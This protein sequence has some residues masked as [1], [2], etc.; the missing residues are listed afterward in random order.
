MTEARGVLTAT[1][2]P[3]RAT[4]A[5]MT[6]GH[7][8]LRVLLDLGRQPLAERDDGHVYPLGLVECQRCGLVQN[9]WQVDRDQ[10]FPADHPYATGDTAALRAHFGGLAAEAALLLGDGDLIV[11][12][13]ANDGT[14]LAQVKRVA[15]RAR[16]LAV[17]PTGQAA[18]CRRQVI[19][20][21]QEFFTFAA[22]RRITAALGQARVITASNVLAHVADQHDFM[23]GVAHLLAPGGTFITENHDLT[24]VINGL[25]I[26]T[27]YHEHLRFYSV[28]SLGYLLSIHGFGAARIEEIPTH[29]GSFR[30]FATRLELDLQGRAGRA[31]EELR[32]LLDFAA[33]DG[34]I[35][36]VGAATR[37][38]PL[39]HFAGLEA[40]LDAI[41]EVPGN[42][43]IGRDFPGTSIPVVD[44]A[45]LTAA[46]PPWAV[47][48]A[49]HIAPTLVP[50]LRAA[51]YTGQFIVPLPRPHIYRG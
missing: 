29:G 13:G 17:E 10:V 21:E 27:V 26:D 3:G 9:S 40:W 31:R 39:I 33:E 28:A 4:S 30:T 35:W 47:L 12:I 7:P 24:A 16:L 25:Q 43:K 36:G 2:I 45:G 46:Q 48:L 19:P 8:Q 42:A 41:A 44:E 38:G 1:D 23:S 14:F 18:G 6:C 51:G 15:P 37:A 50:K 49:W 22:A 32:R 5:C 11:D 20:V 34:A